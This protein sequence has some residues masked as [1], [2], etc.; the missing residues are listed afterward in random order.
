[1]R[2]HDKYRSDINFANN[3]NYKELEENVQSPRNAGDVYMW[4]KI[5]STLIVYTK[6]LK[7]T[8]LT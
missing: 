5:L 3:F 1:M 4:S 7:I 2:L 6:H 8:F